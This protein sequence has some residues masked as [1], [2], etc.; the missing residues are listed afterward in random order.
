[1][2]TQDP[3]AEAEE[4][5][6]DSDKGTDNTGREGASLILD[7]VDEDGDGSDDQR[8]QRQ[9]GE[10]NSSPCA[11]GVA[12]AVPIVGAAISKVLASDARV[13]EREMEVICPAVAPGDDATG[14][15]LHAGRSGP[16]AEEWGKAEHCS[17][18]EDGER[19]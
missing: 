18:D 19:E 13:H 1:M 16:G 9:H 4:V 2:A 12:L 6:H 10:D 11:V 14:T 8:D 7:F 17:E 5:E 15:V 3:E